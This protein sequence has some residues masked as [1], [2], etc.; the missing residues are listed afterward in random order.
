MTATGKRR[1]STLGLGDEAASLRRLGLTVE[2]T[3]DVLGVSRATVLR[4]TKGLDVTPSGEAPE[5]LRTPRAKA[6]WLAMQRDRARRRNQALDRIEARVARVLAAGAQ[7]AARGDNG[8]N[9]G[10]QA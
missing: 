9:V 2:E 4:R 8:P 10:G 6:V 5:R 7:E 3:A 1:R